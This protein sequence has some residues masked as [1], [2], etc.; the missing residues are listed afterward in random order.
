MLNSL[1]FKKALAVFSS[2][3]VYHALPY[4]DQIQKPRFSVL[5]ALLCSFLFQPAFGCHRQ[6]LRQ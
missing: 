3:S 5:E 4:R 1:D 6:G 2:I